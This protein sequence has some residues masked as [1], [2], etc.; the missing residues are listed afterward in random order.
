MFDFRNKRQ[1]GWRRTICSFG[2][3][4]ALLLALPLQ[5]VADGRFEIINAAARQVDGEWLVDGRVDLELSEEALEALRNGVTLAI[6]FQYEVGLRRRFWPDRQVA[7][8]TQAFELQYL[9]LSERY[10]VR[11]LDDGSQNSYAT[12]FSALRYMGQV[13]DYPLAATPP[14]A[15]AGAY[16]MAMRAVLDREQLPGPLQVFAFWQG[17]FSLESA[18]YRWKPN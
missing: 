2:A 3:V 7:A 14:D 6:S 4:V 5:A 16:Y 17:D 13:K 18:W 1:G 10:L 11:Y 9:S 8:T 12:L 15:S